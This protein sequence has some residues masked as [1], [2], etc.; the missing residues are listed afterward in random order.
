MYFTLVMNIHGFE[1]FRMAMASLGANLFGP[2]ASSFKSGI[3][4]GFSATNMNIGNCPIL[5]PDAQLLLLVECE[6]LL[7]NRILFLEP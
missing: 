2:F 3:S 1:P 5:A 4:T 6:H 7:R